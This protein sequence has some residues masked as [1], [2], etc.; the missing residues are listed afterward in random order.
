MESH[1]KF[2]RLVCTGSKRP[3]VRE[4]QPFAGRPRI[5]VEDADQ[6]PAFTT[7]AVFPACCSLV[8]LTILLRCARSFRKLF[9]S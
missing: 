4:R 1:D 3:S 7:G 5:V 8:S 9:A 6:T 2:D